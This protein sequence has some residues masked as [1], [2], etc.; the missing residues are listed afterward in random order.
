M[1]IPLKKLTK[2]DRLFLD[3]QGTQLF[4][5]HPG[6]IEGSTNENS[7]ATWLTF[8]STSFLFTADIKKKQQR[9]IIEN[10]PVVKEADCVQV[11]H[12]GGKVSTKFADFLGPKV[13]I[14]STGK[15]K[16]DKPFFKELAKLQGD[17]YRTD[18]SGTI[19]VESDGKTVQVI[20]E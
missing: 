15:N 7:L 19:V 11:P 20:K 2:G 13:Y 3:K 4:V 6:R 16:W 1:G 14:V 12:H 10:F 8:G 9:A 17:I 5:L 18:V